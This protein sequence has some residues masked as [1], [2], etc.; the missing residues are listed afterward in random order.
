MLAAELWTLCVRSGQSIAT[1]ATILTELAATIRCTAGTIR[2]DI[3]VSRDIDSK[4]IAMHVRRPESTMLQW[5]SKLLDMLSGSPELREYAV[6]SSDWLAGDSSPPRPISPA[7]HASQ[8]M[9]ADCPCFLVHFY[10]KPT[11]VD[12]FTRMLSEEAALVRTLE[13]GNIRFDFLRL[14]S[15]RTQFLVYEVLESSA[16][17]AEHAAMPHYLR[18]RAALEY[19]QAAPRSHDKG[20]AILAP[21]SLHDWRTGPVRLP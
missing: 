18:V 15:D 5:P 1:V 9:I 4:F 20:Y 12:E 8:D 10:I 7:D 14:A 11:Y 3:L 19:M 6:E 13:P 16:A 2:A 21:D 17:L